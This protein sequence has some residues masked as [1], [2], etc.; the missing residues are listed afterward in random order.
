MNGSAAAVPIFWSNGLMA[1]LAWAGC[2]DEAD[3]VPRCS[4]SL[5]R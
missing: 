3:V 5:N 2:E 1:G 4:W